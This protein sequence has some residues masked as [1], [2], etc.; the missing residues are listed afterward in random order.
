MKRLPILAAAL[1]LALGA[2]AAFAQDN[3]HGDRA[4]GQGQDHPQAQAHPQAGDHGGDKP[5][6]GGG[7]HARP[8]DHNPAPAVHRDV[9]R[10]VTTNV[11]RNVTTNVHRNVTQNVHRN[12]TQ[13]VHRNVTTNVR[14]NVDVTQYRRAFQAPRRFHAARAWSPPHGYAYRRFNLG[15]RIPSAFLVADFFLNDFGNYGLVSPPSGYIWVRDGNDAVL[16]NR[17]T[18]EVIQVQYDVF[19]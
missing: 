11:H 13:N 17:Y 16:V 10:N 1:G 5:G 19:Y 6:P 7:D 3:Q 15:E 18:G 2:T 12:V 4:Q 14:R 9:N 8:A